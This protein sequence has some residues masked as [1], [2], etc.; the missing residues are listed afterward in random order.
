MSE[1]IAIIGASVRAAAA[2]AV[3][4]GYQ[5]VAAD[6]FADLDL[7]AIAA[8]T[9]IDDYPHGFVPWLKS[10]SPKPAAWLY[11]GAL[12]NHPDLIDQL[13]TIAPL[14]G[15]PG[16]VLRRVRS[17]WLLAEALADAGLRFPET[18]TTSADLPTDSTWLLK[19]GRGA[20]GT[21]VESWHGQAADAN[22]FLQRRVPGIPCSATFVATGVKSRLLGIARQLVGETWLHAR[23][24]QFCGAISP[25][26]VTHEVLRGIQSIGNALTNRF[27]LRG[28]FGIDLMLDETQAWTIEVNPRLPSSGEIVERAIGTDLLAAHFNACC[29]TTLPQSVCANSSTVFGKAILFSREAVEITRPLKLTAHHRDLDSQSP[30]LA[31]L[32]R[33]GTQIERGHPI[34]T[35][36][37]S[38]ASTDEVAACLKA[39]VAIAEKQ[40][41]V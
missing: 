23:E 26:P 16:E 30:A 6:L 14:W 13:A 24:F 40:L 41:Y 2:S 7:C 17:P 18:R 38:G 27:Q 11:T 21:G 1:R 12:E 29:K 39:R 28:L 19:T 34:V 20:S 15:N 36:F 22:A 25:W 3:R 4:A 33:I 35:I 31:D 37:A 10:L 9:Q 32:P 5:V 8:A